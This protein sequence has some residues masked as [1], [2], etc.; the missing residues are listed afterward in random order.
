MVYFEK[1]PH[2]P[3][4]KEVELVGEKEDERTIQQIHEDNGDRTGDGLMEAAAMVAISMFSMEKHATPHM[5]GGAH[6]LRRFSPK[7]ISR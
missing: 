7:M 3:A 2:I 6:F 1:L 4:R 5:S